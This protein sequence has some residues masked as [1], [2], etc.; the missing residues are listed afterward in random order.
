[1]EPVRLVFRASTK[2]PPEAPFARTVQQASFPLQ[3]QSPLCV[4]LPVLQ[5]SILC[6]EQ[7]SV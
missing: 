7:L 5:A 6:Q 1:V 2:R 3:R 4:M